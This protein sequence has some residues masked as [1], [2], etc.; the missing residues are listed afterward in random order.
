VFEQ[1]S[2]WRKMRDVTLA[3]VR[4]IRPKKNIVGKVNLTDCEAL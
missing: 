4:Y 2:E 3:I 1:Y